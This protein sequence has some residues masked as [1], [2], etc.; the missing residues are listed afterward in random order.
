MARGQVVNS[1]TP[2]TPYSTPTLYTGR[3]FGC[4][5]KSS[6][7][8]PSWIGGLSKECHIDV[9]V[10]SEVCIILSTLKVSLRAKML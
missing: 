4:I 9:T 3:H 2:A 7:K 1:L 6:H 8:G 10:Q 5:E